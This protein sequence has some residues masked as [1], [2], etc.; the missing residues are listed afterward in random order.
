LLFRLKEAGLWLDAPLDGQAEGA[1]AQ[2]AAPVAPVA[3]VAVAGRGGGRGGGRPSK[4][5]VKVTVAL[6]PMIASD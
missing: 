1:K 3:A 4:G 5:F 6:G 2:G